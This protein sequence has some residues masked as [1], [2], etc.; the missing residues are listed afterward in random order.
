MALSANAPRNSRGKVQKH[1]YTVGTGA[2]IYAG[3]LVAVNTA[4]GRAVPATD[5]AARKILGVALGAPGFR[6]D[7][8]TG[9][10]SG[11]EEVEVG[12]G[13]AYFFTNTAALT[14]AYT[15]S[16]CA[17]EDDDSVTTVSDSS[18]SV[19]VGEVMEVTSTGSWVL[20]RN[21]ATSAI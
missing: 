11:G 19:L 5:A 17:V 14:E 15:G 4:T 12:F 6:G 3:A 13:A 20:V 21:F 9:T 18:N 16:N 2:T 8:V 10:A 1:A 7:S